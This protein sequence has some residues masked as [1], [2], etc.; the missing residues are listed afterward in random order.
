MESPLDY[1]NKRAK[2]DW[3]IA[4]DTKGHLYHRASVKFIRF[5]C[6]NFQQLTLFKKPR[7]ND[8][9]LLSWP[10]QV[11]F[12]GHFI[13]ACAAGN[14]IFLMNPNWAKSE[15]EQ[16]THLVES[17]HHLRNIHNWIMI[18]TGGSS[19]K[20]RFAI[21]TWETLM[22]SVQGFQQYFQV[23]QINSFCVLPPYHVSGLMQFMRSFT[24]GGKLVIM[25]SKTLELGVKCDINPEDFFISLVPTQLQRLLQNPELTAWLAKFKT[26]LLGGAPAWR[27]LLEDARRHKIRVAPTYGMTETA[28]QIVT[29]KPEDFLNGNNSA[30]H[31]LP[32][33][34]VTIRSESGEILGT[35]KT[36]IINIAADSLALGYYPE[37]FSNQQHFQTDD[38]GFIDDRGYLNVVGRNSNKIITGGENVFPP[39]VEAAIRETNL[40][41]DVC[42]IGVPDFQWG[43]AVTAVYVA[44]TSAV[45]AEILQAAIASKLTKYKHPK[46][47][48]QVE[49]LPRNAGGKL[50]QD[51]LNK[52]IVKS[53]II[54]SKK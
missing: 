49:S 47:W 32:H 25:P 7:I 30:G 34:K 24:T 29:L 9:T 31:V 15:I 21:H 6:Q 10:D 45:S 39:E 19:G 8:K 27:E 16:V 41:A 37:F 38:L 11:K 42:V 44:N 12:L 54:P 52:I 35:N 36:G 1:I 2:D 18:P 17:N 5:T 14:P 46:Y 48:L 53:R 22:A 40:V 23:S 26:V 20:M 4:Y 51:E 28:S 3:L 13:G 50:N 43:Q 33:A